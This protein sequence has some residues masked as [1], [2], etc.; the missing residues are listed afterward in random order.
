MIE[1]TQL[2]GMHLIG[3]YA[4]TCI[5]IYLYAYASMYMFVYICALF[6]VLPFAFTL[7]LAVNFLPFT[8]FLV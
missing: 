2:H 5:C 7:Y 3:L 4:Y 1:L 6:V 8:Y